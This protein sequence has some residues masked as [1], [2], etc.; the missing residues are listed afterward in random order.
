MELQDAES[1]ALTSLSFPQPLRMRVV[2]AVQLL[3]ALTSLNA[4][5][6]LR[7]REAVRR[8]PELPE[9]WEAPQTQEVWEAPQTQDCRLVD[10]AVLS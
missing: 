7:S 1:S 2:R 10:A 4:M 9:V 3:T 8:H 5:H 6:H